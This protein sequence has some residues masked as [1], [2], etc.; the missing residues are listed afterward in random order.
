MAIDKNQAVLNY[1]L[2]C[3]KIKNSPLYFNFINAKDSHNQII[4]SS[5]DVV[6]NR[7]YLD[8]SV[9]RKYVFTILTFKSITEQPIVKQSG[10][11]NENVDDMSDV[12]T[13]ID[14]I[15]EQEEHH[16]YPDFGD[17]CLVES[18]KTTKD[19]PTLDGINTDVSPSLA[20]YSIVIEIEYLDK[21]HVIWGKGN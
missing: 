5:E 16:N 13:I 19:A 1:L 2:T 7:A 3:N 9:N 8:G 12:Q 15:A 18:I 6:L 21:S 20:M 10:Y 14:W 4:T 17:N 11:M